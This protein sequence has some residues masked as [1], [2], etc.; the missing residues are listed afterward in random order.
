MTKYTQKFKVEKTPDFVLSHSVHNAGNIFSK[1]IHRKWSSFW[2]VNFRGRN[3]ATCYGARVELRWPAL[4]SLRP[5]LWRLR[6]AGSAKDYCLLV[7]GVSTTTAIAPAC[8]LYL[9]Y[10]LQRSNHPDRNL[11]VFPVD[12]LRSGIKL[13]SALVRRK[14][15]EFLFLSW[16]IS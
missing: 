11:S 9:F 4:Y 8:T 3:F 12:C 7:L 2:G 10:S 15:Q 1:N 5:N 14:L 16:P 6:H 13:M